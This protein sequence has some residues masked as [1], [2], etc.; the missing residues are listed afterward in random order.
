MQTELYGK[1]V[2]TFRT[3]SECFNRPDLHT[4]ARAEAAPH[5]CLADATTPHKNTGPEYLKQCTEQYNSV[6]FISLIK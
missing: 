1:Q 5:L 3:G 4:A 2:E 6:F